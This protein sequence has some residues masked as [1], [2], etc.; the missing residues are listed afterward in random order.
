VSFIEENANNV[1]F[2][3]TKKHPDIL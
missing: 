1:I 2:Y 3:K